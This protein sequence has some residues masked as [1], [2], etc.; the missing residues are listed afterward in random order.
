MCSVCGL[1]VCCVGVYV[2]YVIKLCSLCMYGG[3]VRIISNVY[4]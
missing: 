1:Y 3:Y 2:M 4:V